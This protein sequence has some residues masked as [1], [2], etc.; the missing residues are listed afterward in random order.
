MCACM[1]GCILDKGTKLF[2]VCSAFD[3]NAYLS[4]HDFTRWIISNIVK[5]MHAWK[6]GAQSTTQ[7]ISCYEWNLLW[8]SVSCYCMSQM[9]T[10]LRNFIRFSWKDTSHKQFDWSIKLHVTTWRL[11]TKTFPCCST[12]LT[13]FEHC[14]LHN[15]C[16]S[17]ADIIPVIF[18]E[19]GKRFENVRWK[20]LCCYWSVLFPLH[21]S[22]QLDVSI[23][24]TE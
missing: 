7:R 10:S 13:T 21:S 15:N 19:T 18:Q 9:E 3:L 5:S 12:M 16:C 8:I 11:S 24:L 1:Y 23:N 20:K 22:L 4:L 17:V 14:Q 6:I 2:F